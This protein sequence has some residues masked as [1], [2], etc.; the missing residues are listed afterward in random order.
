MSHTFCLF[1]MPSAYEGIGSVID[2]LGVPPIY[3]SSATPQEAD[4]RAIR[5]DWL[6]VSDDFRKTMRL[7]TEESLG[8]KA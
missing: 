4:A 3:N 2:L 8:K 1:S 6:A 5:S 7:V